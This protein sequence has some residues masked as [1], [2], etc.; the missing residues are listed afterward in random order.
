VVW[1][2]LAAVAFGLVVLD[3]V[4]QAALVRLIVPWFENGPPFQVPFSEEDGRAEKIEIETADGLVLQGSLFHHEGFTPRGVIIFCHEFTGSHWTAMAYCEGLY[5]AGFDILSFDFRN[6]GDSD[7]QDGYV[8]LHWISEH[9]MTDVQAAIDYT[10]ARPELSG[11]PIGLFGVSRGGGAALVATAQNA[12]VEAVCSDGGYGTKTLMQFHTPRWALLVVPAWVYRLIPWWHS[13]V[14]LALVRWWSQKRRGVAF[15]Q[16]ER[17]LPRLG[18]RD[19]LLVSGGSDN[20]VTP[21][22]TRTLHEMIGGDVESPWIVPRAKHNRSRAVDNDAYD[23][24]LVEFFGGMPG[25]QPVPE[26]VVS[27]ASGRTD[28]SNL[29]DPAT[30]VVD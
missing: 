24:R 2:T 20:Y 1:V 27:V 5:R 4:I 28:P 15:T 29:A 25:A 21:K 30:V 9:E 16:V 7:V 11:L 8:P 26:P 22:V 10:A 17:W 18:S 19:V 13:L 3:V 14:T 12:A 6:H 23:M